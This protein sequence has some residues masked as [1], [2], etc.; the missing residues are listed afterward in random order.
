M[1]QA[2]GWTRCASSPEAVG[3]GAVSSIYDNLKRYPRE[4][5]LTKLY[6]EASEG[7]LKLFER[8]GFRRRRRNIRS[9]CD[10]LH[11]REVGA[12]SRHIA[13][14]DRAMHDSSMC[15]HIKI[16]QHALLDAASAPVAEKHLAGQKQRFTRDLLHV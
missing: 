14:E 4:L 5:G 3:T 2:G 12:V 9:R 15:A 1:H 8:K 16:R 13:R 10:E 11:G 7:A 6:V